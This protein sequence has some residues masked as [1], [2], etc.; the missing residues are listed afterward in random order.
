MP[1]KFLDKQKAYWWTT[2]LQYKATLEKRVKIL[3][4]LD[5]EIFGLKRQKKLMQ[6]LRK[7]VLS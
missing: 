4:Q 7:Q 3:E 6:P 5:E 1:R 2:L